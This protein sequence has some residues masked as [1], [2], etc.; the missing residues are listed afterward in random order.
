MKYLKTF[1]T[2]GINKAYAVE[3]LLD[4]EVFNEKCPD[5]NCNCD[6]CDCDE[7][8][9]KNCGK[10]FET[11]EVGKTYKYNN[12]NGSSDNGK[13][14]KVIKILDDDRVL[15]SDDSGKE[16]Q[17]NM[18]YLAEAKK[19]KKKESKNWVKPLLK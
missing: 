6:E 11:I 7:C 15:V 13:Q 2:F 12:P 17:T 5:C 3:E 18:E 8:D 14:L 10:K 9:C 19:S 16:L 4:E 1:E